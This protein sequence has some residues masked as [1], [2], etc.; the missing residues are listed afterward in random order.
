MKGVKRCEIL[1]KGSDKVQIT[2]T[3][4]VTESGEVLPYQII[5]EGTPSSQSN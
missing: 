3:I 1:G 5:F 2:V 4:F